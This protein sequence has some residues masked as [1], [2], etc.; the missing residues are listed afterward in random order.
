MEALLK[1]LAGL[2]GIFLSIALWTPGPVAA[3]PYVQIE[4]GIVSREII[5]EDPALENFKVRG[6]ATS[7]RLMA[8]AGVVIGEVLDLYL[9][10]GG[11]DLSID[12]FSDYDAGLSG[13]YGGGLRLNL[14]Q[15]GRRDRLSLFVEGNYLR[16]KTDD[17]AQI[18]F[19]C[20]AASGCS[21]S[22][23]SF[24]PRLADE[25]IDWAEYTVL[26]GMRGHYEGLGPYGGIRLSRVDAEDRIRAAADN[27]FSAAF[28][29][30]PDIKEDDNFGIFLGVDI[31]VDRLEKTAINLEISLIDQNA[32]RAAIRKM[33]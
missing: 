18:E 23:G 30:S 13:A 2:T 9:R 3:G 32:F 5:E 33:F 15:S 26:I 28:Q 8:R 21:T 11:A 7:T 14:Y 19:L 4:T 25:E 17:Q 31:F 29:A 10:G 22:P 24:L 27:N 20:E 1:Y 16:F 6:D 12:E